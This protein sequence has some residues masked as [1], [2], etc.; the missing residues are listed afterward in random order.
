VLK[1]I[2]ILGTRPEIIRLSRIIDILDKH[3]N[4]QLIHTGQNFDFELNKIFFNEL[5]IRKPNFFLDAAGKTAAETIGQIII[6]VDKI[7]AIEQPDAVIVLGDTNSSLS[8]IAA[9]RRK[10]PIFHIE[11]GNRCFDQR[12]P[13]E[14][15][16]KV[17][18]HISD[19]NLTYS[20]LARENLLRENFPPDQVI[21]IGSPMLEVLNYFMPQIHKSKIL[22]KLNLRAEKYFL[23]STHREENIE[24]NISFKKIKI[25]LN[26]I[27]EKY[28]L[29]VIISTHPRTQKKFNETGAKFHKN[30]NLIKPL[31]F[32]DYVNLQMHARCVLSDSGS[33]TEESSILNFPALNIRETHERS[34]GMEE[35]AVMMT[36]LDINRIQKGLEILQSQPRAKERILKIVNDYNVTNVSQ[37]VL[38]II[39]SYTDYINRVVWKKY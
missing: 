33:I 38:R 2:T 7:L 34:E 39:Y 35:A 8:T 32:F 17:V 6:K 14:I 13:E 29:P 31:G 15:N 10:I 23:V 27:A 3:S 25:I 37:K 36:G 28:K 30:V 20:S 24:D 18:D 26:T 9:K 11:A 22:N 12:V 21:K 1:I 16:R 19:I 5:K 4:H